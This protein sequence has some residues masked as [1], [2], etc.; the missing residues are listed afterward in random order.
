MIYSSY[1]F[2]D[3]FSFTSRPPLFV[4]LLFFCVS[5]VNILHFFVLLSANMTFFTYRNEAVEGPLELSEDVSVNIFKQ[6]LDCALKGSFGPWFVAEVQF[7]MHNTSW[8]WIPGNCWDLLCI[9]WR[10][11]KFRTTR[12]SRGALS[13]GAF[14][15]NK[16]LI[17]RFCLQ[18]SL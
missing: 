9:V 11:L 8:T 16:M 4:L 10:N 7:T 5:H 13:V 17:H 6:K 3:R 12:Q 2:T 18:K 15:V 14:P 1:W